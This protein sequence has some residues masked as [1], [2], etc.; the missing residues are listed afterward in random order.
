LCCCCCVPSSWSR[1]GR[2]LDVSA[3]VSRKERGGWGVSVLPSLPSGC[4][5]PRMH[6]MFAAITSMPCIPA[7]RGFGE[8]SRLPGP[9][10][11]SQ[12]TQPES[13]KTAGVSRPPPP[14]DC[15]IVLD[16][17][18]HRLCTVDHRDTTSLALLRGASPDRSSERL[19]CTHRRE[20]QEKTV[21]SREPQRSLELHHNAV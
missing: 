5:D 12:A 6:S 19:L 4:L 17:A 2:S 18:S 13:N 9:A 14:G 10:P 3:S 7:G 8:F 16:F 1:A 15:T 11:P 20:G 21:I